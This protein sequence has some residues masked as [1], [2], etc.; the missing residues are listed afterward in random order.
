MPSIRQSE[1]GYSSDSSNSPYRTAIESTEEIVKAMQAPVPDGTTIGMY[2]DTTGNYLAISLKNNIDL[3]KQTP[4]EAIKSIQRWDNDSGKWI[5]EKNSNV[6]MEIASVVVPLLTQAV[7]KAMGGPAG[8]V[9][10]CVGIGLTGINGVFNVGRE[11]VTALKGESV[12]YARLL[13]GLFIG[14]GAGIYGFG[15][16][17]HLAAA[18]SNSWQSVGA[19]LQGTGAALQTAQALNEKQHEK[20]SKTPKVTTRHTNSFPAKHVPV[21]STS[22]AHGARISDPQQATLP[23]TSRIGHTQ[24][25]KTQGSLGKPRANG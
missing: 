25:G 14:A 20:S 16:A 24:R 2:D 1:S 5:K 23:L 18:I 21:H 12:N 3:E 17:P 15:N 6:K 7:G 4:I 10:Y 22:V 13:G 19:F 11:G 9:V 8:G